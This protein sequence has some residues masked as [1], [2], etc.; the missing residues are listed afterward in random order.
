MAQKYTLSRLTAACLLAAGAVT[1][2][3]GAAAL[4]TG[5]SADSVTVPQAIYTADGVTDGYTGMA[6][7]RSGVTA[8]PARR[9]KAAVKM[10]LPAYPP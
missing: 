1:F 6:A 8:I 10:P 5:T 9:L 3:P 4:E 7:S 2:A